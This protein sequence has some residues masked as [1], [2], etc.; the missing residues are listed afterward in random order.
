MNFRFK[1]QDKKINRV[2]L[3]IAW[4]AAFFAVIFF[5][6]NISFFWKNFSYT[7]FYTSSEKQNSSKF[8]QIIMTADRLAIPKLFIDVPIIYSSTTEEKEFTEALKKGVVHFPATARLGETGNAYIFGHSSDNL[9]SGSKYKTAFALLPKIS[10]GD[11]IYATDA[12]AN[13]YTYK[14]LYSKVVFPNDLSVL[15]QK[16]GGKKILT[17]QTSYPIGTALKRFVVVAELVD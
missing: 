6:L 5:V 3:I 15:G 2:K 11:L 10:K 16:T 1:L 14:V 13:L 7:F 9:W 8:E 4:A 12:S 17:L